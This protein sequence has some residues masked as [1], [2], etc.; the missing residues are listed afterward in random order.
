MDIIKNNAH[1]DFCY[2]YNYAL[3]G[4]GLMCRTLVAAKSADLSSQ[5][6]SKKA[7]AEQGLKDLIAQYEKV[8]KEGQ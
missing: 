4:A 1:T 3:N 2:A 6:A 8:V 5:W 7:G